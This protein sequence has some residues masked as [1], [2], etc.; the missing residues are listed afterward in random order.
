MFK[1]LLLIVIIL[2]ACASSG[3]DNERTGSVQVA[4]EDFG[5]Q[6]CFYAFKSAMASAELLNDGTRE[7]QHEEIDKEI[8]IVFGRNFAEDYSI[9]LRPSLADVADEVG[10]DVRKNNCS[11][12]GNVIFCDPASPRINALLEGGDSELISKGVSTIIHEHVHRYQFSRDERILDWCRD[13]FN[14]TG[15]DRYDYKI[16]EGSALNDFSPEQ[17]AAIV[18]ESVRCRRG[19]STTRNIEGASCETLTLMVEEARLSG[20]F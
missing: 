10:I 17:A 1:L 18:G 16:S 13:D 6:L 5:T 9:Y 11:T 8:E 3:N 15:G 4:G 12:W 20:E 2:E 7:I 14:Q 19:L